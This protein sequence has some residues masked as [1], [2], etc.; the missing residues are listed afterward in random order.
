MSKSNT[1]V[2][3]LHQLVKIGFHTD[4]IFYCVQILIY[5]QENLDLGTILSDETMR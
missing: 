2:V 5:F 3:V 4:V 1:F